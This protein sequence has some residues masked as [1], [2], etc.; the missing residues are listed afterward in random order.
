MENKLLWA[1]ANKT[2][3]QLIL[4]RCDP[5]NLDLGLTYNAGKRGPTQKDVVIGNNYLAPL[6]RKGRTALLKCG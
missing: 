4:E 3:P 2:A 1:A 5:K 6:S